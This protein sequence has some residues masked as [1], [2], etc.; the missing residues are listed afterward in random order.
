MRIAI[1]TDAWHPQIN[2]V[3]R[4][5]STTVGQ[6]L[7]RGHE[8]ELI[9]PGQFRTIGP[10]QNFPAFHKAFSCQDGDKMVRPATTRAK[11]W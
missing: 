8:V 2:G 6:L 11:I 1:C 4:S 10:L 5:I 7:T 3:V 9:T